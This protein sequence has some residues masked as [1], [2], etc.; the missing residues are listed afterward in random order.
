MGLL[1]IFKPKY[2]IVAS[3]LLKEN[4]DAVE[5]YIMK[6]Y[7]IPKD[8]PSED[9]ELFQDYL[10]HYDEEVRPVF[11][12]HPED[13]MYILT[14]KG[15]RALAQNKN[16]ILDLYT[17]FTAY[18]APIVE[19]G[20]FKDALGN[21]VFEDVCSMV[22]PDVKDHI[23]NITRP[24]AVKILERRKDFDRENDF[25]I[26]VISVP[27]KYRVYKSFLRAHNINGIHAGHMYVLDHMEDLEDFIEKDSDYH[28]WLERQRDFSST[29]VKL[30]KDGGL[31]EGFHRWLMTMT[32]PARDGLESKKETIPYFSFEEYADRN[33]IKD[34]TPKELADN[35]LRPNAIR[36]CNKYFEKS[37][38]DLVK[39]FI[40]KIRDKYDRPVNV[41][42][43]HSG[44]SSS[45]WPEFKHYHLDYIIRALQ[46]EGV[47]C[48]DEDFSAIHVG[49][50]VI[51]LEVIGTMKTR[52]TLLQKTVRS[53]PNVCVCYISW[54]Y[55]L[56]ADQVRKRTEEQKQ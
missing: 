30:S 26:K 52:S 20:S 55:K 48:F 18:Q 13:Q 54:L 12:L 35:I 38:D 42:I 2:D 11:F 7:S 47:N 5:A 6:R 14:G 25:T 45:N 28:K 9:R 29:C 3:N 32:F 53:Q 41:V 46:Q 36:N 8:M 24:E 43:G 34:D 51:V 39:E 56:T 31:L 40:L 37:T 21:D 1:D 16:F 44:V 17:T 49:A 27:E 19:L 15:L 22:L 50:N 4:K 10:D 33:D 23:D